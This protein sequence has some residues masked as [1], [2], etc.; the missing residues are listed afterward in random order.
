MRTGMVCLHCTW[1]GVS[2]WQLVWDISI[3]LFLSYYIATGLVCLQGNWTVS[4]CGNWSG[5]SYWELV[6]V[7]S[8]AT[9]MGFLH[10]NWFGL[11]P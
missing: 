1:T 4:L 5:V 2:P 3:E 9:A 8:V 7:V 10:G 6:L 11:C